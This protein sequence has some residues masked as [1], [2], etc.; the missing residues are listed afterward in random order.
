M[1]VAF[2][3][4]TISRKAG[5]EVCLSSPLRGG[6]GAPPSGDSAMTLPARG[7]HSW[8]QLIG[9]YWI[10]ATPSVKCSC[11]V[12]FRGKLCPLPRVPSDDDHTA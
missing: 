4:M 3:N 5:L 8:W 6:G 2:P 11:P 1:A 7:L 9:R 10:R 12:P